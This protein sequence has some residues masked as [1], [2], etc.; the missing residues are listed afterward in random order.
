MNWPA[1]H[2]KN[3]SELVESFD[4]KSNRFQYFDNKSRT[5]FSGSWNSPSRNVKTC[6]PLLYRT[7]GVT[8]GP[9]MPAAAN[10]LK[11][12][13]SGVFDDDTDQSKRYVPPRVEACL[14]G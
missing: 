12:P 14:T 10:P 7:L 8:E 11:R 3:S 13:G 5:W 9:N 6:G 2:P 4:L 1:F